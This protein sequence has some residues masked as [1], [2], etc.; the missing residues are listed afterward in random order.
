MFTVYNRFRFS[1]LIQHTESCD[2]VFRL[3]TEMLGVPETLENVP[4][5]F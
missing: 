5:I 2:T 1:N 4:D 3:H